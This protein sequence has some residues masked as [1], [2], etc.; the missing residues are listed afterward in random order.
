MGCR[1]CGMAVPEDEFHPYLFCV[2]FKG[3]V[4]DPRKFLAMSDWSYTPGQSVIPRKVREVHGSGDRP[5][6]G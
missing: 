5:A 3:G 2:L 4:R 6:D 1:E